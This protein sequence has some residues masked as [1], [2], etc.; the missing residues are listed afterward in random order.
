MAKIAGVDVLLY[1][2]VDNGTGTKE[3]TVVGGQS[4]ATLNRETNVIEV[5]SKESGWAENLSG[6]K[7]WS[8]EAEGYVVV[9]DV[10]YDALEDAWEAGETIEAE[11]VVP[12]GKTYSGECVIA[13]FPLEAP[14]DDAMTFSISLTGTG[15]LVKAPTA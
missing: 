12:S 5:T 13:E 11:I 8:I 14:Q 15:A 3:K 10:A 6:V 2:N 7:S 9:S 4:G 1:A